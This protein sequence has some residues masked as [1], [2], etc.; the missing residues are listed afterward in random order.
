ME[1]PGEITPHS[2]LEQGKNRL[3]ICIRILEELQSEIEQMGED[4]YNS[5]FLSEKIDKLEKVRSE[6]V[7]TEFYLSDSRRLS[8][9]RKVK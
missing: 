5:K 7:M 9:L 3:S 2:R 1:M 4:A 8:F 6:I